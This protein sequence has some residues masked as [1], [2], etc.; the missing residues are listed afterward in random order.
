MTDSDTTY[1]KLSAEQKDK[2]FGNERNRKRRERY[3]SDPE[4]RR[5]RSEQN[6]ESYL[7]RREAEKDRVIPSEPCKQHIIDNAITLDVRREDEMYALGKREVVPRSIIYEALNVSATTLTRWVSCEE[8]PDGSYREVLSRKT[9]RF[10]K[11]SKYYLLSEA[12]RFFDIYVEHRNDESGLELISEEA[13]T[14]F[15]AAHE[16]EFNKLKNE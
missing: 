15:F 13:H 6:R 7:R 16:E 5:K 1:A 10:N 12:L 11:R 3:Q 4:Y 9:M 2:Y 14:Q 8:F